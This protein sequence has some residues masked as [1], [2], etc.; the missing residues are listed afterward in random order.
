MSITFLLLAVIHLKNT[1]S[2]GDFRGHSCSD[3]QI[4]RV[5]KWQS[6]IFAFTHPNLKTPGAVKFSVPER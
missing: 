1:P 6:D 5:Q 4:R 3:H 2:G